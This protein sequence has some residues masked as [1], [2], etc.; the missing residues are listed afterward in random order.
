MKEKK[1]FLEK[2]SGINHFGTKISPLIDHMNDLG[3]DID[4]SM[5]TNDDDDYLDDHDDDD[6]EDF[7]L[8]NLPKDISPSNDG[9]QSVSHDP[10]GSHIMIKPISFGHPPPGFLVDSPVS[11]TINNNNTTKT[12]SPTPE[13]ISLITDNDLGTIEEKD[14]DPEENDGDGSDRNSQLT[15]DSMSG[16]ESLSGSVYSGSNDEM[17]FSDFSGHNSP[18]YV[19]NGRNVLR[20]LSADDY[21]PRILNDPVLRRNCYIPFG[22]GLFLTFVLFVYHLYFVC[23]R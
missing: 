19:N 23:F 5:T 3:D 7:D 17:E 18:R 21:K 15:Q 4:E 22:L 12:T 9:S 14:G 10:P 8:N 16:V 11:T 2:S 6:D 13:P 1:F 20:W